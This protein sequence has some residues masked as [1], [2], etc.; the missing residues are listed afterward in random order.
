PGVPALRRHWA[1]ATSDAIADEAPAFV[2]DLRSEAYVALGPVPDAVPSAYVRVV[3]EQGKALNH[4]NKKAKGEFVR[5]L[6]A[7]RPRI[8][9]LR[10]VQSCAADRASVVRASNSGGVLERVVGG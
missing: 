6:A 3:T 2:L 5:A 7:D 10:A 1:T 9:S 8:R 4:F